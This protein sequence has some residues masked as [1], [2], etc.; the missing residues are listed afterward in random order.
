VNPLTAL[1]IAGPVALVLLIGW[2][3]FG[4]TAADNR[5]DSLATTVREQTARAEAAE[6]REMAMKRA[7]A[8]RVMDGAQLDTMKEELTDAIKSAPRTAPGAAT[9]AAGCIR[10]QRAGLAASPE[11]QRVCGRR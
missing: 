5:A 9:V 10:L 8:E 3:W 6:K 4:W 1:R 11:Y 2:L 7:E